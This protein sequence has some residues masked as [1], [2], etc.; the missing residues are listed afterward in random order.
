MVIL[1]MVLLYKVGSGGTG[2]EMGFS[3]Y[4]RYRGRFD[5][6]FLSLS[7]DVLV[8]ARISS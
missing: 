3:A 8:P 4:K 1:D 2:N 5:M 7:W 6:L